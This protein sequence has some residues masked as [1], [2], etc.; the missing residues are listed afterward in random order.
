MGAVSLVIDNALGQHT[1]NACPA[2]TAGD[3]ICP[4]IGDEVR[5]FPNTSVD[6][7][8]NDVRCA[9]AE[10]PCLRGSDVGQTPLLRPER[11]V[12]CDLGGD[13]GIRHQELGQPIV[14]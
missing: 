3:W 1:T 11:I 7:G 9:N 10:V 4:E 2:V 12:G 8:H 13:R 6:G 5:M 14:H